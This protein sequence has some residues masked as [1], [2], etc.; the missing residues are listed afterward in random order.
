MDKA[1]ELVREEFRQRKM[2]PIVEKTWI[3]L[4]YI[5]C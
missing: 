3:F 1:V 5:Y 2:R 4:K